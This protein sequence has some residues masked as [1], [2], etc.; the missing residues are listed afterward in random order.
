M[1]TE[2]TLLLKTRSSDAGNYPYNSWKT[3]FFAGDFMFERILEFRMAE[4]I[5]LYC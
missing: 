4:K 5:S 3:S 2:Y 1:A